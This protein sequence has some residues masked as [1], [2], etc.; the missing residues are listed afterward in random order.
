MNTPAH[1]ILALAAAGKSD[2]KSRNTALFAGALFPDFMIFFMV[3]W[4][5]WINGLSL[6]Q[7]F[8]ES[9]FS[10]FWQETFA[11]TNSIPLFAALFLVGWVSRIE[12]LW[13]FSLAALLH[14]LCDFPLHHD[15][16][17]P[18]F[19]PF[20]E[21]IFVSP[22]SYW[23]PR[24]HGVPAGWAEA[25]LCVALVAIL[26]RRFRGVIPRIALLVG[27]T[28]ELAFSVGGHLIYG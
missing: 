26:L 11:I 20:S 25:V 16:G 3:G 1:L 24:H 5:R 9:Y 27:L 15:D 23:D 2:G 19:W 18:H 8:N 17:R 12:W 13:A 22:I 14:V 10:D 28:I 7:V 4:E 21:W 6:D